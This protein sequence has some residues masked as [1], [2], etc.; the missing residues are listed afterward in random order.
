MAQEITVQ[1]VG[2]VHMKGVS[3]KGKGSPYEFANI[4]YLRSVKPHF[5]N[6]N[7][8]IKKS[9]FEIATISFSP[10]PAQYSD[11]VHMPFG[12]KVTLIL[13]PD[14]QDIQKSICVGFKRL[15]DKSIMHKSA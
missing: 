6:E 1:V 10:E 9:G 12:S 14:P 13:E 4:E 2:I 5:K 7:T 15:E 3:Q 11:F 8:E